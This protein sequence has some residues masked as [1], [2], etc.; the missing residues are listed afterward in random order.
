MTTLHL[1]L[2]HTNRTNQTNR[3]SRARMQ[4]VLAG[5]RPLVALYDARA[6]GGPAP[7]TGKV[8]VTR[9][10]VA[11]LEAR[12]E[13]PDGPAGCWLVRGSTCTSGY[14]RITLAGA[15][16]LCHRIAYAALHGSIP[17]GSH[18][19]HDVCNTKRCCNPWHVR[20]AT[21]QENTQAAVRDGLIKTGNASPLTRIR[22]EVLVVILQRLADGETV[23][24]LAREYGTSH[25]LISMYKSGKRRR[26][27]TNP[28]PTIL[29]PAGARALAR[30][31]ALAA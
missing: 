25:S 6:A 24:A 27:V 31:L 5:C 13:R 28:G 19:H 29:P 26:S 22:D 30:T 23:T 2:I 11:R 14:A 17:A 21:P 12:I 7:S 8:A 10:M 16:D 9:E 1:T 4:E 3:P 15:T 20:A 18:V